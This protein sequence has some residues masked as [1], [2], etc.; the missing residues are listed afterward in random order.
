M[1][2]RNSWNMAGVRARSYRNRT[3]RL[4]KPIGEKQDSMVGLDRC[5][6]THPQSIVFAAGEVSCCTACGFHMCSCESPEAATDTGANPEHPGT[7]K[8]TG[9]E[10]WANEQIRKGR[11]IRCVSCGCCP[12]C[13][14]AGRT[15]TGP[16]R[17]G[18]PGAVF[19]VVE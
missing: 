15:F 10:A 11:T 17:G 9:D 14:D 5:R 2:D 16:L 3:V 12:E 13:R 4:H 8:T 1:T 6:G 18:W 19:E 7:P